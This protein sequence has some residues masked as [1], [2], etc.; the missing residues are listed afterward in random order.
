VDRVEN[1]HVRVL[2]R[3]IARE[4]R[5]RPGKWLLWLAEQKQPQTKQQRERGEAPRPLKAKTKWNIARA[6][7]TFMLWCEERGVIEKAPKL[8]I[9]K[10][11]PPR[12]D[13]FTWEQVQQVLGAIPWEGRGLFLVGATQALRAGELRALRVSDWR[14]GRL[15]VHRATKGNGVNAPEGPTKARTEHDPVL[16][17]PDAGRWCAERVVG[18]EGDALLFANPRTRGAWSHD[19]V[20]EEWRTACK[21]AGLRYVPFGRVRHTLTST[22]SERGVSDREVRDIGRWTSD[23]MDH[24]VQPVLG[25]EKLRAVLLSS[26]GRSPGAEIETSSDALAEEISSLQQELAE[27]TAWRPGQDRTCDP[28]L[29]SSE[30][31]DEE[32]R[33]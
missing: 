7:R 31:D 29:R 32:P 28:L 22:L 2:L 11:K 25:P 9:A 24:Y 33:S 14:D 6:F 19:A 18:A 17:H 30:E 27:L 23:A 10:P 1:S 13:R 15:Y 3:N 16:W 12:L 8:V 20:T 5:D 21:A 4:T 26:P